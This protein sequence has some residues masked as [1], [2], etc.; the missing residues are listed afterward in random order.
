MLRIIISI[1]GLLLTTCFFSACAQ[2]DNNI[3]SDNSHD[4]TSANP[5]SNT[6]KVKSFKSEYQK[7]GAAVRLKHNYDGHSNIGEPE[8][9]RLSF[10]ESYYTG[11]LNVELK[12]DQGL[13]ITPS[14]NSYSFPMQSENFHSLDINVIPKTDGKHYLKL[15]V[16][17]AESDGSTKHRVFAI[18][19]YVGDSFLPSK[20]RESQQDKSSGETMI[21]LPSEET[22]IR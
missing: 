1:F 12:A 13:I 16:S 11:V 18:A 5:S 22:V 19:F 4:E 2:K 7:P 10:I 8:Q 15:F 20:S 9:V 17:A 14:V 6:K 3:V 21:F